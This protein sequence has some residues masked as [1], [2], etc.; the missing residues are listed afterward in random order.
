[1]PCTICQLHWGNKTI[2]IR[3]L[4]VKLLFWHKIQENIFCKKHRN[5]FEWMFLMSLMKVKGITL[6]FS[7]LNTFLWGA[8]WIARQAYCFWCSNSGARKS[9]LLKGYVMKSLGFADHVISVATTLLLLYHKKPQTC[10][11]VGVAIFQ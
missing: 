10:K 5:S 9:F 3:S 1:M 7:T 6:K 2:C 11:Q 4:E 8:K